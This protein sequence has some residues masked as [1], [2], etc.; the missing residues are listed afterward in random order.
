MKTRVF[1]T[2]SILSLCFYLAGAQENPMVSFSLEKHLGPVISKD[3]SKG[4]HILATVGKDHSLIIWDYPSY[5]FKKK[6]NLPGDPI[7]PASYGK[8]AFLPFK[9]NDADIVLIADNTGDIFETDL[10]K[11]QLQRWLSKNKKKDFNLFQN[12]ENREGIFYDNASESIKTQYSFI[13]VDVKQ[14][15]VIDRVGALSA[16]VSDFVFSLD[17]S[18]VLAVTEGEEA[19]LFDAWGLR[20][21]SQ[22]VFEDE[23][24]LASCFL[25]RNE[26]V[27]ITD[28]NYYKFRISNNIENSAVEK[29]LLIKRSIRGRYDVSKIKIN[30]G[31]NIVYL[32]D[33][34]WGDKNNLFGTTRMKAISLFDGKK[35][36]LPKEDLF[37]PTS[38]DY[39]RKEGIKIEVRHGASF[40]TSEVVELSETQR[41]NIIK[42]MIRNEKVKTFLMND[43]DTIENQKFEYRDNNAARIGYSSKEM[44]F[45]YFD[46]N[47]KIRNVGV[48]NKNGV[49]S[50][51]ELSFNKLRRDRWIDINDDCSIIIYPYGNTPQIWNIVNDGFRINLPIEADAVYPWI[52]KHHFIACLTDGSIRWY[53]AYSGQEE[54]ALFMSKEGHYV[55]WTPDGQ[56]MSDNDALADAIEWRSRRFSNVITT[57]PVDERSKYYRPK[58]IY[59]QIEQLFNPDEKTIS[60]RYSGTIKDL[61][62]IKDITIDSTEYRINYSINAFN[63]Y[64]YGPYNL[65]VTLDD[66][67]EIEDIVHHESKNSSLY[68]SSEQKPQIVEL[69]LIIN[70]QN[71][72]RVLGYDIKPVSGDIIPHELVLTCVGINDYSGFKEYNDLL[73]PIHDANAVKSVFE[74]LHSETVQLDNAVVFHKDVT[75]ESIKQ[76]VNQI[77]MISDSGNLSIFYFS[78]HGERNDGGYMFV[79][80]KEKIPI[81]SILAMA[82]TIPGY[83]L[84][85]FDACYS[86]ASFE[87]EYT[88]T[89]IIASSDALTQSKD[90]SVLRESPFTRALVDILKANIDNGNKLTLD[91]LFQSLIHE[92]G[93]Q[94]KPQLYNNIGTINILH[95]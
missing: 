43:V 89:A 84:F 63:P 32:F 61:V 34:T 64:K 55:I 87:S 17:K 23:K 13:V 9:A 93:N 42:E 59:P 81:A 62:S 30:S 4:S 5:S 86:G 78:G 50:G 45:E 91:E 12:E 54:L 22:F 75:G 65:S 95:P 47:S 37:A 15:K 19:S 14:G 29:E 10:Y 25:N 80:D 26:L 71:K 58:R 85:V 88:N 73:A 16:K 74:T 28:I 40:N 67:I 20:Q 41:S 7:S 68:F 70:D 44:Y 39:K 27:F 82:E 83:K 56:Y 11:S 2:S 35:I 46:S 69:A 18:Y 60:S 79:S 36:K 72:G 1:L 92:N 33:R 77:R 52:N 53:N 31:E 94:G 48:F 66:S 57:R 51:Q 76:R 8:C 24:I 38:E 90:G 6:I 3:I 21:V 49:T